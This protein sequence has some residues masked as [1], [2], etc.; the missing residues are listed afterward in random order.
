MS[1]CTGYDRARGKVTEKRRTENPCAFGAYQLCSTCLATGAAQLGNTCKPVV[2]EGRYRRKK[3]LVFAFCVGLL[4]STLQAVHGCGTGRPEF[5]N[6]GLNHGGQHLF[7]FSGSLFRKNR[8]EVVE[9]KFAFS[10]FGFE[11]ID[12][13]LL[14]F[15]H[16]IFPLGS[17]HA[18]NF[19]WL[20]VS[21]LFIPAEVFCRTGMKTGF[22]TMHSQEPCGYGNL[23]TMIATGAQAGRAKKA[24]GPG[25]AQRFTFSP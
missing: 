16:A 7:H 6:F 24:L 2:A 13:F 22:G 4:A 18:K 9:V 1:L 10:S 14:L 11:K 23:D 25:V 8:K 19:A 5:K 15:I 20:F 12:Y 3:R 21:F 17:F